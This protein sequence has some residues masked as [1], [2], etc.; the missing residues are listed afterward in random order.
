[1]TP[2]LK[3]DL[4]R[5]LAAAGVFAVIMAVDHFGLLPG[6]AENRWLK[7]GLYIIPWL[8]SGYDVLKKAF[9]GIRNGQMLDESFL[10]TIASCG[11][12]VTGECGEAAAVMLFYQLGEWFQRFAVGKSRNSIA[13]LMDLV[14]ECAYIDRGN[15]EIE[16]AD[17][18]DVCVGDI[19]V[20]RPGEK[21]PL[22]GT[23]CSGEGYV[24]TS[25]L[26]GESVPVRVSCGDTVV[27]G[28]VNGESLLHVR[29]DKAYEDSTV[30]KIL[31]MVEEASEK[32][33]RTENFITRFARY[34]TPAVVICAL[35]LAIIPSVVTGKWM[36]W[37]Y[38]ACTFLVISCPCA[39]VISVPLAF[40]GGI[41]A[42]SRNGVLVK[43]S[44]YLELLAG[45]RTVVSDKTGTLT[46]GSFRVR[47]ILP[48]EGVTE[49]EVLFAAAAAESTST[50]PIAVSICEEAEKRR[51]QAGGRIPEVT[52]AEAH[53]GRGVTAVSEDGVI[54]VGSP[55]F[56]RE[57][58]ISC[59]DPDDPAA[60]VC[61]TALGDRYLGTVYI[62]D[63]VKATA[64]GAVAEIRG[65]GTREFVILTGDR[66]GSAEAVRQEVGADSVFAELLPQDKVNRLE[67][68]MKDTRRRPVAFIGDGIN[69]APALMRSDIGIAMGAMG[70][71]AAIEAADV[72]IMDDDLLRI[73]SVMRIAARTVSISKQNIV[74]ALAVKVLILILGAA[75][76]ANMW[77]AVF[78]D[79]GVAVLCILNSM[80]LLAVKKTI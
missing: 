65:G 52:D 55:A 15:G 69:D 45:I 40:F 20:I 26:T 8:M 49:E 36:V 28:C 62:R 44:N 22:D 31:E 76:Y 23:V 7:T 53:A 51:A 3:K 50:H 14:P 6:M 64:P 29:A 75:G 24:D 78:A 61:C 17:P 12:F 63:G 37:I 43:G 66:R 41:G 16:E 13:D 11:A 33:S 73:P 56:L 72:V 42:A 46:E 67:E 4:V 5:F 35:I 48:A 34:Y 32:K 74:F 77:A 21:I 70:S 19:L 9:S 18:D 2:K 30:S 60:Q 54:A 25:A 68:L 71:D 57:R 58:G 10:M 80:R 27:S 59:P 79:V 1:M 38:R 47:S 39:L